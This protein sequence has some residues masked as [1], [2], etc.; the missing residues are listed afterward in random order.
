MAQ[1]FKADSWLVAERQLLFV[2]GGSSL[3]ASNSLRSKFL[4]YAAAELQ[5]FRVFLAE[6]A[7]TDVME[8]HHPR[9][10]NLAE[11]ER[12]LA[13]IADC[14]LIFP[15]SPGS[16][17]ELGYFAAFSDLRQKCLIVNDLRRQAAE[18]FINNGPLSVFNEHSA[19]RPTILIDYN[20]DS[21]N[22]SD[23]QQRLNRF[24]KRRRERLR[25][26]PFDDLQMKS[27]LGLL[28]EIVRHFRILDIETTLH[29][30][31][32]GFQSHTDNPTVHSRIRELLS[33][34]ISAS[35]IQRLDRDSDYFT[36]SDSSFRLLEFG[37]L[38]VNRINSSILNFYREH[39]HDIYRRLR[40]VA[41]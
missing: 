1:A 8:Y 14:I 33:I 37:K 32:V 41:Q 29:I 40:L 28:I 17:S 24:A 26:S 27:Q 2:C 16:L 39:V 23:I 31:R 7:A 10:L 30:L 20:E 12:A 3:P 36:L 6:A 21:P 11:F 25:W 18:S 15:E 35:C 4:Q 34:L 5:A 13:D 38:D 22:F 9:F 19:F